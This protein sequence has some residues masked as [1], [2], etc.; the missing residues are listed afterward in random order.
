MEMPQLDKKIKRALLCK[1]DEILPS[2]DAFSQILA[3]LEK[4]QVRGAFYKSYKHYIIA[5]I[6][7]LSVL[8]GT[9]FV[10]SVNVKSSVLE[11]I[12]TVKTVITLDK[13]NIVIEKDEDEVLKHA[14][15]SN[16]IQLE[17]AGVNVLFVQTLAGCFL[18]NQLND[19]EL[20]LK[21]LILGRTTLAQPWYDH[22]FWHGQVPA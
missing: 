16:H 13:G 8:L 18:L 5:F 22:K 15:I 12:S 7:A 19:W 4:N 14:P 17:K 11:L 9:T 3:G 10:L 21:L 6:C 2:E 20:Y 1:T